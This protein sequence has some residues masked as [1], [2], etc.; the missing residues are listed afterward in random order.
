MLRKQAAGFGINYILHQAQC[1][2]A[3][4]SPPLKLYSRQAASFQ[5]LNQNLHV[6]TENIKS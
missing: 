2:E 6:C 3:K 1:L 4:C 5:S